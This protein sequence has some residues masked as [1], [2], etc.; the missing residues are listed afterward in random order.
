LS[1]YQY[2]LRSGSKRT[3]LFEESK[4]TFSKVNNYVC[5]VKYSLN[6][7]SKDQISLPV[8]GLSY[9]KPEHF[10]LIFKDEEDNI[11]EFIYIEADT[12]RQFIYPK[13][14]KISGNGSLLYKS[15]PI[16]IPGSSLSL[17]YNDIIPLCENN[18]GNLNW[19]F[20]GTETLGD[21]QIARFD[22]SFIEPVELNGVTI[23]TIELSLLKTNSIPIEILFVDPTG[24]TIN[25]ISYED[26]QT[27]IGL[28]DEF[29]D[30]K[31]DEKKL[32]KDVIVEKILTIDED[33]LR[34]DHEELK[35]FTKNLAQLSVDKYSQIRDYSAKFTRKERVN[36]R[37][38]PEESFLIKFRKP[39]DLYMK[40]LNE[41]NDGWEL[42]YA[43]GKHNNKVIVHVTGLINIL[44]PTLELDPS[45]SIAMMNNR[46]SI[47]E[48]GLGYVIENY[49][50]D[51]TKAI[52]KDEVSITYHGVKEVDNRPCWVI[53]AELSNKGVGYYCNRSIIYFDKEYSI[54]TKF[55]FY[56]WNPETNQEELIE[57]Y[58]YTDLSFNNELSRYDFS[59]TN[60]E[61]DF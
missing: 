50:R 11:K 27:N 25:K 31:I 23:K 34:E 30:N 54:P 5:K 36:N 37:I 56:N 17:F 38:Q 60:K 24:L 15:V 6:P 45:G 61:Y 57:E 43:S 52:E 32:K 4:Q 53:E 2:L 46:H 3:R 10:N 26:L 35:K 14:Y 49:Y 51:L 7:D 8:L 28:T 19:N 58:T 16:S 42:L 9:V 20:I 59:R 18:T 39:F 12:H 41:P 44:L 1:Q 21:Q 48:F 33:L 22:I 40:W 13:E 55:V 47:L 29:F